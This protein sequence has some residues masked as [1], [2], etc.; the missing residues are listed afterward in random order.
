MV[1][2]KDRYGSSHKLIAAHMQAFIN[3]PSPSNTLSGLQQFHD[4]VERHI[5]SLS[6]L[7]TSADSYE[8]I[9]VPIILSKLPPTTRKNM[10]KE[11]DEWNLTDLQQTIKK[12]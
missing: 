6:T 10:T 5:H 3:L 11:H 1:L 4:T 8:D 9:L 12:K 7:G 2:L